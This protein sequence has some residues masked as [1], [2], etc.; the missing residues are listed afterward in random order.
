[1]RN[2]IMHDHTGNII[3]VTVS[4]II[5]IFIDILVCQV[6]ASINGQLNKENSWSAL[7]QCTFEFLMLVK[8][9]DIVAHV[10]GECKM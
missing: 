2:N 4:D 10:M 6:M 9:C 7:Y 3:P 5:I 8:R 1:M